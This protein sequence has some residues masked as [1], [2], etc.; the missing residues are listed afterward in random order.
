M[1]CFDNG[2]RVFVIDEG[3]D[4]FF[5]ILNDLGS[6]TECLVVVFF[7]FREEKEKEF[8]STLTTMPCYWPSAVY[9]LQ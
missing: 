7:S 6:L 1:W 4:F 9:L 3:S 8:D 2:L 5:H